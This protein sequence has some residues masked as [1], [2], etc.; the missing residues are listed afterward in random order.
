VG[1]IFTKASGHPVTDSLFGKPELRVG[2]ML[3]CEKNR[4]KC[5]PTHTLPNLKHNCSENVVQQF[6]LAHFQQNC[7]KKRNAQMVKMRP[8]CP[9]F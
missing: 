6:E 5:R 2:Q 1:D 3:L 8:L 7:P 4:P 9:P